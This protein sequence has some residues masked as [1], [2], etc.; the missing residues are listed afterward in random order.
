[1]LLGGATLR[2]AFSPGAAD[3]CVD[4]GPDPVQHRGHELHRGAKMAFRIPKHTNTDDSAPRRAFPRV[5]GP[6]VPSAV[7]AVKHEI[8]EYK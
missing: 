6:F 2:S 3:L 1:M 4:K 8:C 5:R 7:S